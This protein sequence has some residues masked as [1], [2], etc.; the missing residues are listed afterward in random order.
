MRDLRSPNALQQLRAIN[1]IIKEGDAG[2]DAVPLLAQRL[3]S[4]V[5]Q[6]SFRAAQALGVLGDRGVPALTRGLK[7]PEPET[8]RKAAWG[9]AIAGPAARE[10]T[11]ALM[12]A[13]MDANAEVRQ[14]AALS[15]GRTGARDA[16]PAL[17]ARHRDEEDPLAREALANALYMLGDAAPVMTAPVRVIEDRGGP[18]RPP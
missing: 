17:R 3:E 13:L 8:R 6:V 1:A 12:N 7:S 15:L 18:E 5:P 11:R 4:P 10:S 14:Q 2:N 9:L 16:I